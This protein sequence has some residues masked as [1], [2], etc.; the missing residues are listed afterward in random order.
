MR[1]CPGKCGRYVRGP[2]LMCPECTKHVNPA[3]DRELRRTWREWLKRGS[4]GAMRDYERAAAAAIRDAERWQT[5]R[6][7]G[8]SAPHPTPET[9]A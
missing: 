7:G 4:L 3:R 9:D 2:D 6:N 8:R 1:A 5:E